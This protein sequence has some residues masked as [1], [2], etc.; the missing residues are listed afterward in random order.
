MAHNLE[1]AHDCASEISHDGESTYVSS[2]PGRSGQRLG[3]GHVTNE[4]KFTLEL[5][6]GTA[7]C[8]VD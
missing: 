2:L 5:F 3:A 6:D 8:L 1:V 4:G 7:I